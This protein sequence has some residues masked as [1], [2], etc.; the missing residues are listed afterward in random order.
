MQLLDLKNVHSSSEQLS[1]HSDNG[2]SQ[3]N[4]DKDPGEHGDLLV[5]LSSHTQHTREGEREIIEGLLEVCFMDGLLQ[6]NTVVKRLTSTKS[7]TS[8]VD[9]RDPLQN[10]KRVIIRQMWVFSV[11]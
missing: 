7:G 1:I 11:P 5:G 3:P 2:G 8:K 4:N 9:P 6:Y 10:L